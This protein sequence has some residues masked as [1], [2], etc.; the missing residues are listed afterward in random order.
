MAVAAAAVAYLAA[1]Q[2]FDMGELR[3]VGRLR[4]PLP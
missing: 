2:A 3:A 1:A 4:R